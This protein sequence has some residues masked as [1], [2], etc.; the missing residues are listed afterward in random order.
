M[1]SL[2]KPSKCGLIMPISAID[3]YSE[4]HWEDVRTIITESLIDTPF[5]VELV[6]DSNEIGIIQKRIVQN[7]YDNDIVI[8]DVSGKNPNVMFELGLRLAFDKPAIIIKDNETNY[9]FDTAPIEHIGY[10]S[11]L[12]YHSI[13]AFKQKLKEKVMATYEASKNP[14]YTTFLKHFGQFVVANLEE[15]KVSSDEY[16]LAQISE[17]KSEIRQMIKQFQSNSSNS[18]PQ[19]RLSALLGHPIANLNPDSIFAISS[20][21]PPPIVQHHLAEAEFIRSKSN[22]L[23]SKSKLLAPKSKEFDKLLAQ[24]LTEHAPGN[25]TFD[26]TD[27][28]VIE[29]NLRKAIEDRLP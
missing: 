16:M 28:S 4:A 24:Y 10:R 9:S 12:H 2:Q 23:P 14:E 8:C 20:P 18:T 1:K 29:K 13:Q 21:P 26:T 15:K 22:E 5:S 3:N 19:G 6:S 25:I 11:D 17:L 27:H 7:V